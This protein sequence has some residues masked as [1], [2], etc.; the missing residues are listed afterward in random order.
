MLIRKQDIYSLPVEHWGDLNVEELEIA[1]E[2]A[3]LKHHHTWILPQLVAWFGTWKIL[4]NGKDTIVHNCDTKLKRVWYLLSRINRSTLIPT[5]TKFPEYGTLTPLIMMG[6]KRST[7]KQYESWRCYPGLEWILEPRLYSAVMLDSYEFC[8]LGS[9]R[10]LEI[11]T[12]GLTGRSGKVAG[13]VKA[14]ESTW[15]LSGIKDTELGH[16]PKLTQTI[17]TQCWLSNPKHRTPYM[18]LDPQNWDRMPDPLITQEI[19]KQPTTKPLTA[20]VEKPSAA[21][22][23]D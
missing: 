16:L 19:F 15:S 23:W 20:V 1:V 2:A 12:Q 9:D 21:L 17:V 10:L 3:Q 18:I 4:D 8:S 5:Q 14:A 13:V 7:N 11:R 22:P 6:F